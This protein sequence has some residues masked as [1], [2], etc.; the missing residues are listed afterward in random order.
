MVCNG[1]VSVDVENAAC[2]L[3]LSAV[4]P[5]SVVVGALCAGAPF[6]EGSYTAA[7][8]SSTNGG[9]RPTIVA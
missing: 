5:A 2:P 7:C 8:H 6:D 4:G 1:T 3:P 9:K